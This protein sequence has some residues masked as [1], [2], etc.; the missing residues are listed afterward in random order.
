[1]K[2]GIYLKFTPEELKLR[3]NM[4]A[5]W[6]DMKP[7][8]KEQL[9]SS[10]KTLDDICRFQQGYPR[11]VNSKINPGVYI[12]GCVFNETEN[13]NDRP[14]IAMVKAVEE[15]L[16]KQETEYAV[17]SH[18]IRDLAYDTDSDG[19][20]IELSQS[21]G[22]ENNT[23][24][25][26]LTAHSSIYNLGHSDV[27][28]SYIEDYLLQLRRMWKTKNEQKVKEMIDFSNQILRNNPTEEKHDW[29]IIKSAT[30]NQLATKV[31]DYFD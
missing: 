19:H 16:K 28:P 30:A 29:Y 9:R 12:K 27:S 22:W 13:I 26:S 15:Q 2:K 7:E 14:F 31:K 11:L 17:R 1:M 8:I 18:G 4:T 24:G 5:A 21:D 10:W 6:K 3:Y 20:H 23:L 25:I